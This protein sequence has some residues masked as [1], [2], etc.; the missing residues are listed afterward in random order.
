M[1][2]PFTIEGHQYPLIPTG[3]QFYENSI[4]TV[5]NVSF[6]DELTFDK[7]I[8]VKHIVMVRLYNLDNKYRYMHL[9][10]FTDVIKNNKLIDGK[11]KG[12]FKYGK[13]SETY[14]IYLQNNIIE[15]KDKYMDIQTKK[16]VF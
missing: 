10:D 7:F 8:L 11:I 12:I 5:N 15:S 4:Q 16:G 2:I 14:Y 6:E 3:K 13:D 1:R 9:N